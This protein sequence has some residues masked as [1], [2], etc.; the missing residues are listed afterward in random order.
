MT[1]EPSIHNRERKVS[2]NSGGK[3]GQ[4]N[5]KKMKLDYYLTPYIQ[6]NSK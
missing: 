5:A 2:T 4:L 6:T 3:T 1:K